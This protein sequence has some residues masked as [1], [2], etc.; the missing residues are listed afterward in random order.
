M[1]QMLKLDSI[2]RAEDYNTKYTSHH[3]G[4]YFGS[5]SHYVVGLQSCRE[6]EDLVALDFAKLRVSVPHMV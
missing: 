2:T 1:V 5:S 3:Y 6:Q 4:R